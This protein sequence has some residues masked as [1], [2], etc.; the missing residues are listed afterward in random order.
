MGDTPG[1]TP[2]TDGEG[3]WEDDW[4]QG[5][6]HF[7]KSYQES[8]WTVAVC[9]NCWAWIFTSNFDIT[10]D[11]WFT[12]CDRQSN[13]PQRC[14]HHDRGNLGTCYLTQQRGI[15]FPRQLVLRQRIY[16]IIKWVQCNYEFFEL[17]ERGGKEPGSVRRCEKC[18]CERR[19][20]SNVSGLENAGR[21]H[22]PRN[23]GSC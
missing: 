17:E 1:V 4:G 9:D 2:S 8:R 7:L 23:V 22:E 12:D 18:V 16:W 5:W 3:I 10:G 13:G 15:K 14:P 19:T 6:E 21:G 11:I 20:Q